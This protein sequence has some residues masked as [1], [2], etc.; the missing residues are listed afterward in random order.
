MHVGFDVQGKVEWARL[1]NSFGTRLLRRI[2]NLAGPIQVLSGI[3]PRLGGEVYRVTFDRD[4]TPV[5]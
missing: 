2:N 3:Q 5:G 1:E 4:P